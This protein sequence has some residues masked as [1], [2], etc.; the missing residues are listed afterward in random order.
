MPLASFTEVEPDVGSEV[1]EEEEDEKHEPFMITD[2]GI[3]MTKHEPS[4]IKNSGIGMTTHDEH[5]APET[6]VMV[7]AEGLGTVRRAAI[8]LSFC[9]PAVPGEDECDEFRGPCTAMLLEH[10]IFELAFAFVG[11]ETLQEE[12][13]AVASC[14]YIVD[15]LDANYPAVSW[16]E[17]G[18]FLRATRA[19]VAEHEPM[20]S[21]P[22][23]RAIADEHENKSVPP[24]GALSFKSFALFEHG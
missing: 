24:R 7:I 6:R 14:F 11:R 19:I 12:S 18:P 2:P 20:K 23:A 5:V 17:L 3:R 21:V 22:L 16:E 10:A 1:G 13:E 9:F 8:P 4:M 15:W